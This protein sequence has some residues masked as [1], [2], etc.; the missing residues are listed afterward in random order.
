MAM[1]QTMETGRPT[2][3]IEKTIEIAAPVE[4]VWKALTDA[5]ELIR[6]FPLDARVK[7]GANGSVWFSWKN[8]YEFEM[9]VATWE[10][11]QRLQ[12]VWSQSDGESKTGEAPLGSSGSF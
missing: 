7:P 9:P 3:S 8:E 5:E 6:W 12:L 11:N 2:R 10:P 1:A 4:A